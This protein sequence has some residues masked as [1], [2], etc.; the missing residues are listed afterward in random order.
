MKK[1][2]NYIYS[3]LSA[4]LSGAGSAILQLNLVPGVYSDHSWTVYIQSAA[5]GA[6]IGLANFFVRSPLAPTDA[7][8]DSVI[9]ERKD[10]AD[11]D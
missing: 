2:E 1:F 11:L 4:L 8:V 6:L 3:A 5:I 7:S 9:K 10:A